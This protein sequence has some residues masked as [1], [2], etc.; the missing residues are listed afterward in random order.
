MRVLVTGHDGYIG[1]IMVPKLQAAGHQVVGLD[2]YLFATCAFGEATPP[3]PALQKD[4]RDVTARD[5]EGF[6][7][8]IHLAALSNDPLGDLNPACTYDINHLASVRLARSAKEAG[9]PRFLFSSS[10]SLYGRAGDAMLKEDAPFN[11]VTPYGISKVRVEADVFRLADATFSPTFLRNATAYGVSPR[12]RNDLVV[13]NLVALACATGEVLVASDGTP[14]RPL[15][16]VEDIARAFLAVLHAPRELIHNQA[17][18][19]GRSEENY[20]VRDIAEMV[21]AVVPGSRVRYAEGGGPDPRCYRVDCDKLAKTLPEFAPRWTV[22]K[23]I[24]QLHVAFLRHG[25]TRDESQGTR[26]MRIKH[27]RT[28]QGSGRLDASLRWVAANTVA[29]GP[30]R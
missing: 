27:I 18:N 16:H 19:V 30:A 2:T 29:G 13:N 11:P 28:L 21:R 1:T 5:L 26:Y 4:V 15:V 8:V 9:V 17:F 6:D 12:L 20:Q 7:A 22:R 25:L 24:E 10:C 14:W 3:V 23:G